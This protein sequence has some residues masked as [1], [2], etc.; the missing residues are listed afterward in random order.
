MKVS[1]GDPLEAI[2]P[3]IISPYFRQQLWD[4]LFEL[5]RKYGSKATMFIALYY[6]RATFS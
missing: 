4:A 3:L 5:E 1:A 2:F 6:I